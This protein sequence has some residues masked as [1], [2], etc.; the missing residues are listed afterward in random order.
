[1]SNSNPSNDLL[2]AKAC[3][4]HFKWIFHTS[5]QYFR[6]LR[7]RVDFHVTRK[8][9]LSHYSHH[10]PSAN[11]FSELSAATFVDVLA[12]DSSS[13]LIVSSKTTEKVCLSLIEYLCL[14]H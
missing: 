11:H 14:F 9:M 1:M 3:F 13:T 8:S 12:S 6:D 10:A 7:T 4:R 5:V 2:I